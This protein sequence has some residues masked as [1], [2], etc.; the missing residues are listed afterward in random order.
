LAAVIYGKPDEDL[1]GDIEALVRKIEGNHA[2]VIEDWSG[3]PE[4]FSRM[5]QM[6]TPLLYNTTHLTRE[7]IEEVT[8][9]EELALLSAV[10]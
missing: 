2:G 1:R 5:H 6:I 3:D 8:M 10:D 7:D 4:V 9:S